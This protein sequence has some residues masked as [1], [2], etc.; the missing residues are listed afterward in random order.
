MSNV[1]RQLEDLF[2]DDEPLRPQ[3]MVR[4]G[5]PL[6]DVLLGLGIESLWLAGADEELL[7]LWHEN[8]DLEPPENLVG[9]AARFDG[10]EPAEE[11]EWES[12]G[13]GAWLFW[14]PFSSGSTLSHEAILL[15]RIAHP[16]G[17]DAASAEIALDQIVESRS[18]LTAVAVNL[19][20][21]RRQ[22]QEVPT[23]K[24]RLDQLIRQQLVFQQEHARIVAMNLEE[25]DARINEQKYMERLE[26]EVAVRT[27]EIREQADR[28]REA[29]LRMKRDLRAAAR[30]QKALLPTALP[31]ITGTDFAWFYQPC[32]ELAGDSLNVFRLDERHVGA[33][34]LDVSGHGVPAALLSVTL[35][36]VLSP[37]LDQS[38]IL[39]RRI[40]GPPWYRVVSPVE[41]ADMLNQQFQM[42]Q[43]AEQ[44]F[45][46]LYVLLDIQTWTLRYVSAGHPG[47][48]FHRLGEPARIVERPGFPIGW[49]PQTKYKEDVLQ[50]QP[51][52]RVFL[53]SDGV[54]EATDSQKEQFGN[55]RLLECVETTR[56]KSVQETIDHMVEKVLAWSGDTPPKDD[57]SIVGLAI[58]DSLVP[59]PPADTDSSPDSS[60]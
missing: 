36:R 41:V 17:G 21:I 29:N 2:G 10:E 15:G 5:D 14:F 8:G 31:Q 32:E 45:T 18:W 38:S 59:K 51:G 42:D 40:E 35:S 54:T 39:K 27:R 23:L 6:A 28:L 53:Y 55:P 50:L 47:L 22:A 11:V 3:T 56:G 44:Y 19:A 1:E 52:D 16:A 34:I 7:P 46:F 4:G 13:P 48:V 20:E 43:E 24:A 60:S 12:D 49:F 58:D 33:Y 9:L 25:R 26:R 30:I 57:L 37:L